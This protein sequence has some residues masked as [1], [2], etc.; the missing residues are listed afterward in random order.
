MSMGNSVRMDRYMDEQTYRA[1]LAAMK[2]REDFIIN[3]V[4]LVIFAVFMFSISF[5]IFAHAWSV[6]T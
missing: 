3:S 1:R 5:F 2:D 4:L 6:L